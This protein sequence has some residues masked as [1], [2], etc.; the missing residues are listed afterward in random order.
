MT[1]DSGPRLQALGQ[2]L[3]SVHDGLRSDLARLRADVLAGS[4]RRT[5]PAHCLAFCAALSEHHTREDAGL[6]PALEER[7]PELGEVLDKLREDHRVIATLLTAVEAAVAELP[8]EPSED[9]LET[10]GQQ[11]DGI[12]A[13]MESHFRF[14][15]RRVVGLLGGWPSASS[16]DQLFGAPRTS[17]FPVRSR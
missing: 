3:V 12:G 10:F 17:S 2:Q 9:E 14:E 6:F 4:S 11:I 8:P 16:A 5:L 15:E 7:H 13:I 1:T